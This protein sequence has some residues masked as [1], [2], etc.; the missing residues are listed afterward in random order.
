MLVTV[1]PHAAINPVVRQRQHLEHACAQLKPVPA[2]R[3]LSAWP[4]AHLPPLPVFG[5]AKC[6]DGDAPRLKKT[7]PPC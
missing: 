2:P 6:D 5:V 4:S 7:E 1:R 3:K